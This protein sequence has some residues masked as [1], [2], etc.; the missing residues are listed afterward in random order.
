[1]KKR[2]A[3]PAWIPPTEDPLDLARRHVETAKRLVSEQRTRLEGL[4]PGDRNRAEAEKLLVNLEAALYTM[5]G[6][7]QYEENKLHKKA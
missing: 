4:H 3:K 6:H 2:A 1:M 5:L 7:L